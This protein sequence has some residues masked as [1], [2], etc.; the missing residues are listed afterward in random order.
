MSAWRL[1]R[2]ADVRAWLAELFRINPQ[3]EDG[4]AF[5]HVYEA[6]VWRE[7]LVGYGIAAA[8]V[9]ALGLG[10]WWWRRASVG[11]HQDGTPA[12]LSKPAPYVGGGF[13]YKRK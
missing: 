4:V 10:V 1:K 13:Y 11:S 12:H 3:H 2:P 8:V 9:V 7:G 6:Y 5:M